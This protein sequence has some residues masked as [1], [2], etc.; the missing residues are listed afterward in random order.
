MKKARDLADC[1]VPE[2]R[3]EKGSPSGTAHLRGSQLAV[4]C[5]GL[6]SLLTLAACTPD[7]T[8]AAA[9]AAQDFHRA[10][11]AGHVSEACS[12]LQAETREKTAGTGGAGSCEN[13]LRGQQLPDAGNILHTDIYGR[14]ALVE[15]EKDTVFLTASKDG[16]K[17]TAA[18]CTPNGEAPYLCDVGG[19]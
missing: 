18:G 8:A 14:H 5:A 10:F 4:A 9:A 6:L 13:H 7:R 2:H 19:T 17:I 11:I 3:Q 15:F 12:L 1:A 16:W